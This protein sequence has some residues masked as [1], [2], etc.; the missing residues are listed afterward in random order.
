MIDPIGAFTKG[1]VSHTYS[2]VLMLVLGIVISTHQSKKR[3]HTRYYP[4]C[5]LE[6]SFGAAL[7][8]Y[9]PIGMLIL[10]SAETSLANWNAHFGHAEAEVSFTS[11]KTV[12][13]AETGGRRAGRHWA[14]RL[15]VAEARQAA[16]HGLGWVRHN[17]RREPPPRQHTRHDRAQR[18]RGRMVMDN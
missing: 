14:V 15:P 16:R 17:L 3:L 4:G 6:R 5:W 10:G 7:R 8:P 2:H 11:W 13:T 12:G 1:S 9:W 18:T